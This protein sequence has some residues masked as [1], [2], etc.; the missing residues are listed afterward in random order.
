MNLEERTETLN[1]KRI[2]LTFKEFELLRLF[3][4]HPGR[5][6][7]REQLFAQVWQMEYF[8]DSRTLDSHIRSLRHKIE[9]YGNKIETVRNVGY[10]WEMEN[11]K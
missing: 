11:G 3:L 9:K 10:R 1:G 4:S 7:T 5:V 2:Q 6:Y 8:E